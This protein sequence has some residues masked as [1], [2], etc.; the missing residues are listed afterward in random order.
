MNTKRKTNSIVTSRVDD[1]GVITIDVIGADS[2]VFDPRKVDPAMRV[3]AERHGW[4]QRLMDGAALSRDPD[5]GRP[6]TPAAKQARIQ[7]IADHY[8]N[9]ATDWN[10]R[11]IGGGAKASE[12]AIILRALANVADVSVESM[13]ARVD[14]L[15]E[16][17]GKK[18]AALLRIMANRADIAAEVARL[19]SDAAKATGIDADELIG[20]L[21]GE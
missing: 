20:E 11:G 5:T 6:A 19:K 4:L 17:R 15:A 9:G 10:M 7:S 14:G 8:L 2:V 21:I 3:R 12:S 13:K 1:E 18:L 16:R